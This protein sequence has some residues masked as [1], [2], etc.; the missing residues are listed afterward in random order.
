MKKGPLKLV[1]TPSRGLKPSGNPKPPPSTL[2][3]AGRD[4][5]LMVHQQFLVDDAGSKALFLECCRAADRIS[6]FSKL[7]NRDGPLITNRHGDVRENP[8]LKHELLARN[9]L[10][11]SLVRLGVIDPPKKPLGRPS[12]LGNLGV[13]DAYHRFED[14]AS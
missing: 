7:I 1:E 2:G 10:A 11:Q 6:E 14:D 13:G 4:L 9:F 5:W 8:L 3:P 12:G